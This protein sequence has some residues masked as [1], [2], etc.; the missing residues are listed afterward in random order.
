MKKTIIFALFLIFSFNLLS[1]DEDLLILKTPFG[2]SQKKEGKSKLPLEARMETLWFIALSHIK[3]Q[4]FAL[5]EVDVKKII[6]EAGS[7]DIKRFS[8]FAIASIGL[9]YDALKRDETLQ[10]Q[11]FLKFATFFNPDL[12]ELYFAKA[13]FAWRQKSYLSYF[14]NIFIALLKIHQNNNYSLSFVINI[15]I[16][17]FI[18]ALLILIVFTLFLLYRN[19][20]KIKHDLMELFLKKYNNISAFIIALSLILLPVILGLNWFWILCYLCIIV[21]G[22]SKNSERIILTVLVI[23]QI[24]ALPLIYYNMNKFYKS[25]SPIIQ[26]IYALHNNDLSYKY[27]PEIEI[28]SNFMEDPDL[29]FLLGNLYEASG[30]TINSIAAYKKAIS[31]NPAHGLSYVGLG[32]QYFWQANFNAAITEYT[33]AQKYLP[34]FTPLYFNLSKAYNQGYQYN[35]GTET[36]NAGMAINSRQML[37]FISSKP[38]REILPVY[39]SI[40]DGWKLLEK[41]N[42]TGVLKGKG[43]RGHEKVYELK[44]SFT[45]PYTISFILCLILMIFFHWW[46][47]KNW[48][49]AGICTKC[50]RSFCSKCK[51]AAESQ[52]YCTQ[53]IHIYIKKDGVSLDTKVKKMNE[54]KRFLRQ[55]HYLKKIFNI[56]VPGFGYLM[57]E[58]KIKGILL[59]FFFFIL[60]LYIFFPFP[61][62]FYSFKSLSLVFLKKIGLGLLAILWLVGNIRIMLEKGGI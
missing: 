59:I 32:N 41:I 36:L 46:R 43:I 34:F 12:P 38:K 4:Q 13:D 2:D 8:P 16:L 3:E 33:N 28:I 24:L 9:F 7:W 11:Y 15:Y 1:Q 26:S 31:K 62:Y 49:Y 17:F 61:F 55:E 30:D 5:A 42:N 6:E 48:A 44:T 52:I 25:F 27:V 39:L 23:I 45:Y 22:Y 54:V 19:F 18:L 56:L 14:I 10:A 60:L 20:P 35:K 47:K 29:I 58:K 21:F 57:E 50:G 51:S 37:K 53:C 40:E